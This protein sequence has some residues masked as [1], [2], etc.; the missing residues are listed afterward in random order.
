MEQIKKYKWYILIPIGVIIWHFISMNILGGFE[1]TDDQ[2][3]ALIQEMDPGFEPIAE[4]LFELE[5]DLGETL[6][7]IFQS[8]VGLGVMIWVFLRSKKLSKIE[9]D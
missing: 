9:Q 5:T 8:L 7:F 2:S 4:S 3:V 6:M 1:G